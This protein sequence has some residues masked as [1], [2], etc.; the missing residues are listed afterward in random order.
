MSTTHA[1]RRNRN[2][3][4]TRAGVP[5]G[6]RFAEKAHDAGVVSLT[7][8]PTASRRVFQADLNRFN[9]MF[10]ELDA[11]V[12]EDGKIVGIDPERAPAD[13]LGAYQRLTSYGYANGLTQ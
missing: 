1:P 9:D 4:R 5:A 11:F 12:I 2:Q 3:N 10:E 13:V 6:G 7:A 8:T